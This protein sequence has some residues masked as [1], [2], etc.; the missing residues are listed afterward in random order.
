[1]TRLSIWL[2]GFF[3]LPP[4]PQADEDKFIVDIIG[5][6]GERDREKN[7]RHAEHPS[8][9][10]DADQ[11]PYRGD[12]ENTAEQLRFQHVSVA[13]LENHSEN[14]KPECV[15]GIDQNKDNGADDASDQR[16]E[17]RSQVCHPYNHGDQNGV[18][19]ACDHLEDKVCQADNQAV[20][21][22]TE[23]IPDQ[24]RVAVK[25]EI[26]YFP[27]ALWGEQKLQQGDK[28]TDQTVFVQQKIDGK[29][30]G[31]DSVHDIAADAAECADQAVRRR[32]KGIFQGAKQARSDI[33]KPLDHR[34][35]AGRIG[36]QPVNEAPEGFN[37]SAQVF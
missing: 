35:L 5:N 26:R 17:G 30:K 16:T 13:G 25:P 21:Q 1:M 23:D 15:P 12:A 36:Q 10:N 9:H 29:N 33:C 20:D 3:F 2:T 18:W 22:V 6:G 31:N 37:I 8:A 32:G 11:N 7:T 28:P 14:D 19:K 24:D 27:V 4:F 34:V